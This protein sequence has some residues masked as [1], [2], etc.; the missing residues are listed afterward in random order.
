MKEVYLYKKLGEK[1]VQCL[2]CGHKCVILPGKRGICMVRENIDGKLYALNYGKI[3][4]RHIDPIE[5][6]PL[7]HFLPGTKTYSIAATGCNFKCGNCQNWSISQASGIFDGEDFTPQK[8]VEAA[9][10]TDCPSIAYTYTEP[11]IFLEF[12]LD[13]M[14]IAKKKG[15]KNVWVSNGFMTKESAKLVIPY[16]D[17]NNIDIKGFSDDFYRQNCGARLQPVLETAKLMKKSGVWIEIT[18]LAISGM[19]DSEEMFKGIA[20][21]IKEELGPETPWHISRFFGD[22]SWKLGH[23]P[24]TPLKTLKMAYQIGKKSGLKYVYIGNID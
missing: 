1:K 21:F 14:K 11:T 24:E 8:I 10:K 15:I 2:V 13:A 17:A 9:K 3:V 23:L 6:K 4:A 19:S 18:T 22:L 5:K 16:L 12:A 7:F 20:K